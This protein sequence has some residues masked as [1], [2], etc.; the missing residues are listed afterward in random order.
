MLCLVLHKLNPHLPV[1]NLVLHNIVLSNFKFQACSSG[2]VYRDE[3][4]TLQRVI[5]ILFK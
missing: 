4:L 3:H 1:E 2:V 5:D